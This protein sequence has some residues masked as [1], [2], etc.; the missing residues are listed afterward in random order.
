MNLIDN[1]NFNNIKDSKMNLLFLETKQRDK[2]NTKTN[3]EA[4]NGNSI[5]NFNNYKKIWFQNR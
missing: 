2:Q 1:Q 3:N 5:N 4:E